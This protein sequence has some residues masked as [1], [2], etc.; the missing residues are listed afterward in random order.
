MTKVKI[1]SVKSHQTGFKFVE[2]S[3]FV[4]GKKPNQPYVEKFE[5]IENENDK[6]RI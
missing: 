5:R 2:T 1:I 4:S 3:F 6:K